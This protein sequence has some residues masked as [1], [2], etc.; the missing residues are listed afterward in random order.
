VNEPAFEIHTTD[1]HAFKVYDDGRVE[2]FPVGVRVVNRIPRCIAEAVAALAPP[3]IM[4]D[5]EACA[6]ILADPVAVRELMRPDGIIV[7]KDGDPI[8]SAET[9][10]KA[11]GIVLQREVTREEADALRGEVLR[12]GGPVFLGEDPDSPQWSERDMAFLK[13]ERT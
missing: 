2:G 3:P 5:E 11:R 6:R 8:P 4:V 1:G 10:N 13:G 7:I 9:L 12:V